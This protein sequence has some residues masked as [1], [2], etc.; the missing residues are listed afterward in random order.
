[1]TQK[2]DKFLEE[3]D[4][5][6][7]YYFS[8]EDAFCEIG[9]KCDL[10]FKAKLEL[11]QKKYQEEEAKNMASEESSIYFFTQSM[12]KK[13]SFLLTIIMLNQIWEQQIQLFTSTT[14]QKSAEKWLLKNKNI[15]L[16]NFKEIEELHHLTNTLK[17]GDGKS[18]KLLQE[19]NPSLFMD[20]FLDIEN[21]LNYSNKLNKGIFTDNFSINVTRDDFIRYLQGIQVFWRDFP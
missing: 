4:F 1:M 11:Y 8:M 16:D 6:E 14:N 7:N 3:I 18:A 9:V 5:V 19:L 13:N 10:L 17:H 20:N 12:I 2:I 21:T 15:A